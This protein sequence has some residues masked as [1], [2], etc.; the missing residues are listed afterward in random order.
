MQRSDPAR[1]A[2]D[3]GATVGFQRRGDPGSVG[4][5]DGEDLTTMYRRWLSEVWGAGRYEVA[6]ELLH[7]DLVDHNAY[8]GQPPGRA[9]DTW[10]AQMVRRAFPDL[11]FTAD[12]V[13]SDGEYVAGS[14]R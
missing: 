11:V 13:L 8:E 6:D 10:A 2:L 12:V 3:D 9:G 4:I 14:W 1:N 5:V 7:A